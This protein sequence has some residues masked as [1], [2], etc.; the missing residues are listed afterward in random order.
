MVR[1]RLFA[2]VSARDGRVAFAFVLIA[3]V[4]FSLLD[5]T[6]TAVALAAGGREGNPIAASVFSG[7]GDTGL[8]VFKAV[9]VAVIVAGLVFVPRRIMSQRVALWLAAAFAVVAAFTVI[10]N[11]QAYASLQHVQH[12]PAYDTTAPAVRLI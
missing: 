4:L 2:R 6:T 3:Y 12:G 7:F 10:H 11:V 8:L 1:S 9:V 5:W